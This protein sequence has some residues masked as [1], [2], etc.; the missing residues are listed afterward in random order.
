MTVYKEMLI[1]LIEYLEEC[2]ETDFGIPQNRDRCSGA[3]FTTYYDMSSVEEKQ[4]AT[5]IMNT[6]SDLDIDPLERGHPERD[7]EIQDYKE[8]VLNVIQRLKQVAY[9]DGKPWLKDT[10]PKWIIR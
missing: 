1:E 9:D 5:W 4:L 3:M 8:E 10:R 6:G 2:V 7:D